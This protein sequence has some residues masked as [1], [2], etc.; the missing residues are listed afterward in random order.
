LLEDRLLFVLI[1]YARFI[2]S[3]KTTTKEQKPSFW[4]NFSFFSRSAYL[5][6]SRSQFNMYLLERAWLSSADF[7]QTNLWVYRSFCPKI[8]VCPLE[9]S[10]ITLPAKW[11]TLL[12]L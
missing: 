6:I 8:K 3:R 2:P 10:S 11:E 5:L 1:K 4:A 9:V 7:A 12:Y